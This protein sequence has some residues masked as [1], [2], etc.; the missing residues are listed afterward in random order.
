MSGPSLKK[1]DAHSLIHE[2]ALNEA[3][4]LRDIFQRCLEDGQKEKALQV[5]EVIIE[6]WETRTLK[7]AESEEEGLYKE[8]VLENPQ[9]KD[10]VVQLTRDHDIM[11]RIVQQMKEMLQKQEVDEEFTT[12]MDGVIIVDLIHNEDEMNKLLPNNKH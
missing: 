12:L 2:A 4:E 10:L 9:L 5:A 8:M 6:H 7:H 3:K 11:R 1:Q